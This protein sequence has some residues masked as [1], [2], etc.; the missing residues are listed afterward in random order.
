MS[1]F[2]RC[3]P[4]AILLFD[5]FLRPVP[6]IFEQYSFFLIY[7]VM[8]DKDKSMRW[9]LQSEQ[10][11]PHFKSL[12]RE[13]AIGC[14]GWS[15]SGVAHAD[16][17]HCSKSICNATEKHFSRKKILW[18]IFIPLDPLANL[19]MQFGCAGWLMTQNGKVESQTIFFPFLC[20]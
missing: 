12:S 1:F 15:S 2:K 8:S 5:S 19:H 4:F 11:R 10:P 16:Y 3:F 17:S 14:T 20:V 9:W 13:E 6:I 7:S 18:S